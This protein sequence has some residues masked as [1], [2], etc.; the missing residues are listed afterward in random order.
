MRRE[1]EMNKRLGRKGQRRG[2]RMDNTE[3]LKN[4][5]GPMKVLSFLILMCF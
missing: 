3:M 2:Q 1:D 4:P 5:F